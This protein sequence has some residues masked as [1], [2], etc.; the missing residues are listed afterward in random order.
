AY[1]DKDTSSPI[2]GIDVINAS[3]LAN[4][5]WAYNVHHYYKPSALGYLH[6]QRAIHMRTNV[7]TLPV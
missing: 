1:S 3:S 7:P 2:W 4:R 6:S 5:T